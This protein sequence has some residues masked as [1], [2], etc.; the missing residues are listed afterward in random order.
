[1]KTN[2]LKDILLKAKDAIQ[3]GVNHRAFDMNSVLGGIDK[4][5]KYL[6]GADLIDLNKVWHQAK[7]KMPDIYGGRFNDYLCVHKFRPSGHTHLTH[8][9]NCPEL[10]EYLKRNPNDWWCNVWNLLKSE[11]N[12][13]K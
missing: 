6:D 11:H 10:E 1:M 2:E 8:E 7:D 13:L 4:A 9:E 5:V 12:E 3:R